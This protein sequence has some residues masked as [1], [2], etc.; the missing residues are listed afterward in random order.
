VDSYRIDQVLVS[1]LSDDGKTPLP[2]PRQR[3]SCRCTP[4]WRIPA[5]VATAAGGRA[6][7][8]GPSVP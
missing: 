2:P 5:P 6:R 7:K 8:P 4:A 1:R 3:P